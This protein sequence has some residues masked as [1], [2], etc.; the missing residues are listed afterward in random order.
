MKNIYDLT[1]P[2]KNIWLVQ[3]FNKNSDINNISG[4]LKIKN[5]KFN[6]DVYNK[7][8]NL[9]VEKNEALRTKIIIEN[10][11]PKQYFEEY[12]HFEVETVDLSKKTKKQIDA[13]LKLEYSKPIDIFSK[14]YEFKILKYDDNN[15][16]ILYKIHHIIA[17]AWALLNIATQFSCFC[18][19]LYNNQVID[20]KNMPSYVDYINSEN[21]Y[22]KSNNYINDKNFWSEYLKSYTNGAISLS[23][24]QKDQ[25]NNKSKRYSACLNDNQVIKIN[26]FCK[27]NKI[28][29]YVLF[30]TALAT[31][32][33][34]TKNINDF[35]IGTPV[36]NRKNYIE[37]Q[38]VGMFVSTIPM[39]FKITEN[40]SLLDF[41]KNIFINN[42]NIYRHQKFPYSRILADSY[43]SSLNNKRNLY[44]IAL[45][46][47]NA[48]AHFDDNQMY[49]IE[50]K[51]DEYI[52]DELD[53]HIVDLTGDNSLQIDYDYCT[54]KYSLEDIKYLAQRLFSIIF[55]F[56]SDK[57]L[58]VENVNIMNSNELISIK[59][60]N[61]TKTNYP[62]DLTVAQV[63]E[64]QV[65]A[66]PQNI[67][68]VFDNKSIT[69]DSLNK[70]ANMAANYLINLG[71][72]PKDIV[73][74]MLDK[75]FNLYIYILAILK[76]GAIYEPIDA[77]FP[78]KRIEYMIKNSNAAFLIT[79]KSNLNLN[80]EKI[81]INDIDL[82]SFDSDNLNMSCITSHDTA[83]ILYTSGTTG[84][85][86]GVIIN[87]C[88]ILRLVKNTNYIEFKENDRM[89]Q[90]SSV[91]FDAFTY[92]CWGALLNSLPLYII[93]KKDLL[94][95][96]K[97]KSYLLSNKITLMLL[98]PALFNQM[99]DYDSKIFKSIRV[100]LVGGDVLSIKHIKK[101]LNSC[102]NLKI[103]DAYGPT[104]NSTISSTYQI[105]N[106]ISSNIPIGKP[107]SNSFC[108]VLDNKLRILPHK[109]LGQL[110]V[111]GD[112]ISSG[113]INNKELTSS[114]FIQNSFDQ[115]YKMYN[116]GDIVY[117]D[118]NNNICFVGR[119]DF[120]T[121]IRGFRIELNEIK[122]ILLKYKYIKDCVVSV[123]EDSKNQNDKKILVYYISKN[124]LNVD[125]VN[126][127]LKQYLPYYMIPSVYIKI[128]EMPLN[129]HG[130]VDF[131]ELDKIYQNQ[132]KQELKINKPKT[133][134]QKKLK[135]I[136]SNILQTDVTDVSQSLFNYGLDSLNSIKISIQLHE[137]F[138][139]DID[140]SDVFLNSNIL[141][142]EKYIL[143][144][145]NKQEKNQLKLKIEDKYPLTHSQNGIF[146][147]YL[148][149]TESIKYN[150]PFEI[151]FNKMV[152]VL[153][154]KRAIE[155]TVVSNKT[156][157]TKIIVIN[158][159][160]YQKLDD[161]ISYNLN[162]ENVN[163]A[164]YLSIKSQFNQ[165]FN[166]LSDRL[167]KINMY[168]AED[169][170]YVLFN[171]SHI[172]F[173]GASLTI[174]LKELNANYKDSYKYTKTNLDT[175][176][177]LFFGQLAEVEKSIENT[178]KY[179][180]AKKYF[181]NMFSGT[182]PVN[183]FIANRFRSKVMTYIGDDY[184]YRISE[185]L[186][187]KFSNFAK[188]NKITLNSLFLSAFNVIL[189]K[190]MYSED[191]IVGIAN[192]GR[193]KKYELDTIGMFVK[194]IPYRIKIDYK[195][196]ILDFLENTQNDMLKL[197]RYSM[198]PFDTLVK[199]LKVQRDSSRNPLFDVMFVF[200]D[201]INSNYKIGTNNVEMHE[202][203]SKTS[204]FD[205]TCNVITKGK[206]IEIGLE[207]NTDI[208][209][210]K[211]IMCFTK[212]YINILK[213][214][215][216][217]FDKSLYDID[218]LD[219]KEKDY[220]F[221]K[222]NNTKTNYPKDETV[223]SIFEK[224]V[225]KNKEKV[226]L[227]YKDKKL[228][229]FELNKKANQLAHELLKHN[230]NQQE[231]I[232]VL[233]DKSIEYIIALIAILKVNCVYMSVGE[234]IPIERA[235]YM[236]NNSDSKLILTTKE[237]DRKDI[238][239]KEK[240]Y[241]DLDDENQIYI[242]NSTSNLNIKNKSTDKIHIIY[243]SGST[244]V[245]KGNIILHKGIIRLLMNTNYVDFTSDDIMLAT[246]SITFDISGFEV[247]G[248]ILYGMT[249]HLVG[250]SVILNPG[251]YSKYLLDNKITTT[252]IPTPLFNQYAEYNPK[253]LQTLKAVY[254]GGDTF[255]PKYANLVH[256]N[257]KN[258]KIYNCY[259]PAENTVVCLA[260]CIDRRF[261]N[262]I[263][264]GHIASNS[265]CFVVDK[266]QKLCSF[267][268]PGEIYVG[269][270]GLG[271]GYINNKKLT[272]EKFIVPQF[273]DKRL[274]KSGDLG[275]LNYD[276]SISFVERIDFQ[277]KIRGQR[278]EILEIE[279]RI[280]KLPQIKEVV[281]KSLEDN[282]KN[283]YLV[284][285]YTTKSHIKPEKIKEY[286]SK[287][288]TSYMM[289]SRLVELPKMPLN[290]NHKIDRFALP[291]IKLQ[292][293][294][295]NMNPQNSNQQKILNLY[296]YTLNKENI[297]MNDNF[298][299]IGGDSILAI[300][301][302]SKANDSG[303]NIKYADVFKYPT[304]LKMYNMIYF[305]NFKE[306]DK[307]ISNYDYKKINQLLKSSDKYIS[308]LNKNTKNVQ[309][310]L[311]IGVTGF[312]GAHIL[313]SFINDYEGKIY[314]LMR[315]KDKMTILQRINQVLD[316]YFSGKYKEQI[317]NRIVL[318]NGDITKKNLGLSIDMYKDVIENVDCVINSAAYVK[319]YGVE[320]NFYDINFTSAKNIC[321]F[322]I[323]NNKKL[324]QISTLSISGNAVE[325]GNNYKNYFK[326]KKYFKE[327]D[328][329]IGQ[330][331]DNI[332]V[333]TK[334]LAERYVLQSVAEGKLNA[335][336]LRI[337]NLTN[338]Y[339][340]CK[341]QSNISENAFLNRIKALTTLKVLPE[342][343]LDIY[344]EFTPVDYAAKAIVRLIN[345]DDN[346]PIYHIFDNN[347]VQ[348]KEFIEILKEFNINI[349]IISEEET[350]ILIDKYL[351]DASN[352]K[353]IDGIIQD[354]DENKKIEYKTNIVVKSDYTVDALKNMDFIWPKI[355]KNYII[356]F[357]NYF[358]KYLLKI[359]N[360]KDNYSEF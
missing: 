315:K 94:N 22:T 145:E 213:Y 350:K 210:R 135:T 34:R 77:E 2:Q 101:A 76:I 116:T 270:E 226:A 172:I 131:K 177:K 27:E 219:D 235:K 26:N 247:W 74:V 72:K 351:K 59:N 306:Y 133:L 222:L 195:T 311:L 171:F 20:Q 132:K 331:L 43:K 8:L 277:L 205:L 273:I 326:E 180:E 103:I 31:Y 191:I 194:T 128:E 92:E 153:K 182:L 239:C 216:N 309:N 146:S 141:N 353:L 355:D 271:L 347:H 267:K 198:Y 167:F 336:I 344:L 312:L 49:K 166:L 296:K 325:S 169:N 16:A 158:N 288:L 90:V 245:P 28:S 211:D 152:D 208:F 243:T 229:Y 118:Y 310:I 87:N 147:Y 305:N 220:I 179:L 255:L 345:S 284:A 62:K 278:V 83:C 66:H 269:G 285:Y 291:Y 329:Y 207:Y 289:P 252:F 155:T 52:Q 256:R 302:I 297:G 348:I 19:K 262:D 86:K 246:G 299:E 6:Y 337:G 212:H 214:I 333:Y 257:C 276:S 290:Q 13:F 38:T 44:N 114:K 324:L 327:D 14:L 100:L 184:F 51:P 24:N 241:I 136:V 203:K 236:I 303:I 181:E 200:H 223:N 58:T 148:L 320:K 102:K 17:D 190:Y 53:I 237:F 119:N 196:K 3:M 67:S 142:L 338:R 115:N 259:S 304:P 334:F 84:N 301:L 225:L 69:Y 134:I 137:Q 129:A 40:Q 35:I 359:D 36:L 64:N 314:C 168:I 105:S 202:I 294:S 138:S 170:V 248:A 199:D 11:E 113:Y 316:F 253:M 88:G 183:N 9:L 161:D 21:I 85:P 254:V 47:Q 30:L 104:E 231:T 342:N 120:Q 233:I 175:N 73:A 192:S 356:K 360:R 4:L 150:I 162:I 173:D 339:S 61:N 156:L 281:V 279:N 292:D 224:N 93:L 249:L 265:I 154:L 29:P 111:S 54:D 25:I 57:T 274:Y 68:L 217:N 163:E 272:D 280:L 140:P 263:P 238:S 18:E 352:V 41:A 95:P 126:K 160:V 266:C 46:Y 275:Y 323:K 221:N 144:N 300:R 321:N 91:T 298:F 358:E 80:I 139:V 117:I 1:Y 349:K 164:Q 15:T 343:L 193:N 109:V 121:K 332:Y 63:F 341:F 176:N 357:L 33:Y 123:K 322:C 228:S 45:S 10:D 127:F 82:T 125:K 318:V 197:L 65:K 187:N 32:I 12:M 185:D 50:W 283:K 307:D 75:S 340:D 206:N 230:I 70:Y 60:L 251:I 78:Q 178:P 81:N 106:K 261:K 328:L 286:I 268:V 258:T 215:I 149:D 56:I 5:K 240:I 23:L 282:N 354:I 209:K 293:E 48:R 319:H 112:G 295:L 7:A 55:D 96:E 308:T 218:M 108:Y 98:T 260:Q 143:N 39:R 124:Y 287:Y 330:R 189:S 201:K 186:A 107:I 110:F 99:I 188:Q 313:D 346:L 165:P 122:D 71:I 42:I 97:F 174:F 89:I 335:K 234:N 130:K 264:L 159:Q 317:N 242:K 157:F 227:V 204:K 232:C 250:N 37:K 79:D 244:G 151:K